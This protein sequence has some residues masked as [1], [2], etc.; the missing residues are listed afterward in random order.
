[1]QAAE[2]KVSPIQTNKKVGRPKKNLGGRPKKNTAHLKPVA[3]IAVQKS[4]GRSQSRFEQLQSIEKDR[5]LKVGTTEFDL[6][7][8]G[9]KVTLEG[10]DV[11]T[12]SKEETQ[13]LHAWLAGWMVG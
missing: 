7:A 12:L 6:S 1:M 10:G 4:A 2:K 9:L 13:K 5:A 11:G 3:P 8:D